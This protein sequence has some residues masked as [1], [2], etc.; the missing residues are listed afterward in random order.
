MDQDVH[1]DD[2]INERKRSTPNRAVEHSSHFVEREGSSQC[3]C[4]GKERG[5]E[6]AVILH[7]KTKGN[8]IA[9]STT[10]QKHQQHEHEKQQPV[11]TEVGDELEPAPSQ[12]SEPNELRLRLR[13]SGINIIYIYMMLILMWLVCSSSSRLARFAHSQPDPAQE[14]E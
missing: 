12:P 5:G 4:R 11:A 10:T 8:L 14:D 2:N 9:Q 6:A 7:V 3:L 1:Q 13:L